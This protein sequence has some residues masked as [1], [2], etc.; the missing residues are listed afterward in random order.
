MFQPSE[1]RP[2]E[3][4]INL[5]AIQHNIQVVKNQM[6]A[7]QLLYATVKANAYGHG[8]VPVAKAALEA[9]A[10]GILVATVD[11]G[12]ALRQAGL[13]QVPILVLGLT[14]PRGIAEILHY[15]LTVTVGDATFFDRAYEQLQATGQLQLLQ[16]Y[17]LRFHLALDTGMGRIGL[18]EKDQVAAF[19]AAVAAYPWAIWEGVFTHFATAG[20]GPQG[21]I[22]QQFD[23]W[24]DLT[25]DLPE[26][27]IY[28]HYANSAMGLW[29]QRQ[30]ASDI[31][32]LGIAMY[33]MDPKD[34]PASQLASP[35]NQLRP[36][37]TLVSELVY[38]KKV[39][40]G[41]PISYG[42]TYVTDQDTWVGTVPIGYADGWLRHYQPV[43][44]LVNG[45]RCP[46]LGRIN[47]DQLMIALPSDLPVG[48]QVTLIGQDG[49]LVNSAIE[50]ARQVDTISYEIFCGLSQRVPRIYIQ[51]EEEPLC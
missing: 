38:V 3:A 30:P 49:N 21:L 29:H 7:G 19:T 26:S 45:L 1:H 51:D 27:V 44:L 22:Q 34:R 5:S 2:T 31:V 39:P 42:A 50:I 36:A 24:L 6:Q 8:A 13:A 11:E 43:D 14:D 41:Q 12:I 17:R 15:N 20:G 48:T 10:N 4:I 16:L 28:K 23:K 25:A 47:M 35:E 18:R 46:V 40:A 37:L 9:G 32:R 33:G